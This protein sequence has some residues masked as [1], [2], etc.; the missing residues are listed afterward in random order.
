MPQE[1]IDGFVARLFDKDPPTAWPD[2]LPL[3]Y[4]SE[5]RPPSV[6]ITVLLLTFYPAINIFFWLVIQNLYPDR[7]IDV[8]LSD[9][10]NIRPNEPAGDDAGGNGAPSVETLAPNLIGSNSA[11][12]TRSSAA[13]QVASTAPS[14]GGQKKKRV[15]LGTKHKQD[16]VAADRVVIELLPYRGSRSPL[17]IVVVEHIFGRLLEAFRHISQAARTDT[18]VGDDAQPSKRARAPSLKRLLVPKYVIT[19]LAYSII[20][21]DPYSDITAIHRRPS[22]SSQPKPAT[23]QVTILKTA[24]PVATAAASSLAGGTG[25]TVLSTADAWDSS[26]RVTEF[27]EGLKNREADRE[28]IPFALLDA[29]IH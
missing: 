23:K 25:W 16:K 5:N 19:L 4:S 2:T 13:N 15:M 8:A 26:W 11:G 27:L 14:G 10:N 21:L 17:D 6:R 22:A 18:F 1:E 20:N 24:A 9:E 7:E 12:E 3:S 29:S 28:G